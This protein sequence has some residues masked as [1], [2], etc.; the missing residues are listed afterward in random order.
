MFKKIATATTLSLFVLFANYSI[1]E[2]SSTTIQLEVEKGKCDKC[3]NKKCEGKC[4]TKKESTA[5]TAETKK[6][7]CSEGASK[8]CASK[9]VEGKKEEEKK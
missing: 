3:G 4:D 7:C 6:G 9:K 2:T 5:T 1:A 8:S